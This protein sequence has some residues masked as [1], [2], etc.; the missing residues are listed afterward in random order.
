MRFIHTAWYCMCD[1]F[2]F[3]SLLHIFSAFPIS[4]LLALFGMQQHDHCENQVR[5][6]LLCPFFFFFFSSHTCSFCSYIPVCSCPYMLQCS[7][8]S[9]QK[10]LYFN[11]YVILLSGQDVFE[12]LNFK[13]SY[14]GLCTCVCS[15]ARLFTEQH[16]QILLHHHQLQ[17]LINSQQ[18]TP[19][20]GAPTH[21][22]F[23]HSQF[24]M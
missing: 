6:G 2:I 4:L 23:E 1:A 16:R 15:A 9:I 13:F 11:L 3:A 21:S 18:V 7:C 19:V 22:L 10:G 17:Q 12:M 5:I 8:L 24:F 14:G 20:R